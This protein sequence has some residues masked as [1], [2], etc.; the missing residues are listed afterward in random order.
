[1]VKKTQ[2]E[3]SGLQYKKLKISYKALISI[4]IIIGVF[5]VLIFNFRCDE[6][7]PSLNPIDTKI[8]IKK[9]VGG[10]DRE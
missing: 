9:S 5:I 3:F 8:E 4:F 2:K 7:G 6:K 1:M 10:G